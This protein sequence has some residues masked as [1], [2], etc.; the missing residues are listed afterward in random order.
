ME[1][2]ICNRL[3]SF[4]GQ[5]VLECSFLQGANTYGQLGQGLK[6]EQCILPGEIKTKDSLDLSCITS[7][8]GGGGHTL[9]VNTHG[10][11]F[12][13]G[14]NNKG[15]LGLGM[16]TESLVFEEIK[17]LD[18]YHVIK[19]ACGWESSLAVTQDGELLVWGSN[20]YCQLGLPKKKVITEI[21]LL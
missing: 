17:S 6:S 8:E 11:V 12:A 13:C 9:I 18:S 1:P 4:W 2:C 3:F 21:I 15:Q 5:N 7:I 10:Q 14:S 20:A 19:V 16:N